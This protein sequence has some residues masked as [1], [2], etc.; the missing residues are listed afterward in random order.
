MPVSVNDYSSYDQQIWDEEL[1]DFVP[2]RVFDAHIHMFHPDHLKT[3]S[4]SAP[5][6]WGFADFSTLQQ[7]ATRL[8][9]GEKLIS[10]S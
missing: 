4:L 1:Q 9:P 10:W 2:K 5:S 3:S 7:W 6:P 8:Y